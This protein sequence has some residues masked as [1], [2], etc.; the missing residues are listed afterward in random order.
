MI[1]LDY[2]KTSKNEFD[3]GSLIKS[4]KVKRENRN[5]DTKEEKYIVAYSSHSII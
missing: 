4:Q 1:F 3:L 5:L 2:V